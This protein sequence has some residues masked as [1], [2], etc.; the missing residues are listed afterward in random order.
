MSKHLL[1][2]SDLTKSEINAIFENA[3]LLKERHKIGIPY[4]PLIGKTLCLVFAKASTRTRVSFEAAMY[5]LGGNAIF[6][7]EA[8]SQM[9]RGEPIKDTARV[10]SRYADGIVIRTFGHAMVK[11]FARYSSMPVINGLTDLHHPCQV[12]TDVFT[13]IE[14]KNECKG[15]K[16]AWIGDGN[17]MA[18]SWIEA[19][20]KLEFDLQL[21][22]PDKYQ[23][24]KNI[25]EMAKKEAVSKIELVKNPIEA[26]KDA[27]VLTTD[28]WTSMGQEDEMEE[29]KSAF[30]DYQINSEVL[31]L[32][33]SDA[34]VMHC[35][36][37]HRGEE[38][39]ED[40]I[41]SKKSVIFDEAENR[42]HVQKAI[43]EWLLIKN[44]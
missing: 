4:Q 44:N 14:K 25:L 11:E 1:T 2:I 35:M 31:K 16:V 5:Q 7:S 40:V 18:N 32:A 21:A 17:N 41:E 20:S 12:L 9:G 24:D 27:D 19:A 42:L 3:K 36:P 10:L 15:L 23:P 33:K 34:I 26:A 30:K 6:L 22:C 39:T 37:V 13:M 43:L 8:D 29:R 28:V 38:I